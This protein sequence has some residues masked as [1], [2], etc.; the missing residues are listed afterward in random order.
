MQALTARLLSQLTHHNGTG[1]NFS[2]LAR[3]V[4]CSCLTVCG[5][6]LFPAKFNAVTPSQT[7]EKA[8][9]RSGDKR[10]FTKI[11]M[12]LQTTLFL[13]ALASVVNGQLCVP[14][15]LNCNDVLPTIFKIG[16][17]SCACDSKA[18]DGALKYFNGKLFVCLNSEWKALHLSEINEYGTEHNPG[19]SC[20]DILEKADGKY[21][22]DGVYWIG[23]RLSGIHL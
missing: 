15:T 22:S 10:L 20:K 17:Q 8:T 14:E 21:L 16:D 23:I 1:V 13:A 4:T 19:S 18:H 5:I 11:K 3:H 12:I 9:E 6:L 7:L 2:R